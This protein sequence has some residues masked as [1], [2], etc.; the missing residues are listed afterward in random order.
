[1]PRSRRRAVTRDALRSLLTA[2]RLLRV[3]E[4]LCLSGEKHA[5][6]AGLLALQDAV[7]LV[8]LACIEIGSKA[9]DDFEGADDFGRL[10]KEAAHRG[11][12]LYKPEVLRSMNRMRAVVKHQ[13][14]LVRH[15]LREPR[16][17]EVLL[18][19]A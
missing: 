3:A 13:P 9:E 10:L 7:E 4:P 19:G 1:M 5:A 8:L 16:G 17:D 6:S 14:V 12:K 15:D 2:K 11:V 18:E